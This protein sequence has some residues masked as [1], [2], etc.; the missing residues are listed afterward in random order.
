MK[1]QFDSNQEYQ[2]DAIKAVVDIFAGQT[3]ESDE[4]SVVKESNTN[5]QG[6]FIENTSLGNHLQITNSQITKNVHEIQRRNSLP[7]SSTL[8]GG[9]SS[10]MPGVMIPGARLTGAPGNMQLR[11]GNNFTIEMETGTGK[12]Y[13]YLRTIHELHKTYGF[14][15]FIIVVPSVAIKEGVIKNL[16]ITRD[17][18]ANIYGNP[19]MDYHVWDPRKRGQA[20]AFS[21]NNSLQ[22]LVLTIDSFTR[23]ENIINQKSDWG[24]PIEMVRSTHPI[25]ILDEP[26]NMETDK[27]KDAIARLNPLSTL[28]YSATHKYPY[29]LVYKLDPVKAYDLGLV[30]KIEVDSVM[31]EDSFNQAYL[32]VEKIAPKGKGGIVAHIEVDK[33]DSR[34]LQRKTII[35]NAGDN[36][37]DLTGRE[38][39]REFTIDTIDATNQL[40][41]CSNGKIYHVGQQEDGLRDQ[42]AKYQ[43][44]QTVENHFEKE[45]KLHNQ[46]IKV[47]SLFFID[48]VSNYRQYSEDGV[49]KGKFAL[50][51]D[52]I[53]Q[54][55][56]SKPK[57][58]DLPKHEA[59]TVHNGYFSADKHGTWLDT[60]GDTKGDDD[61]YE[62]IMRDKERLL[63]PEIPLRFIFTHSALREGWDNP[64]VFQICTLRE[65]GS[66]GE[67]RQ[68]I[69]RGLRLPVNIHGERIRDESVN[70]LTVIA[71]ESYESFAKTLQTEI[72]DE[73]GI[74]FGNRVKDKRKRKTLKLKKNYQLDEGFIS[75]WNKIKQKTTFSVNYDTST[76]IEKAVNE[77][78][79]I[80][81][82]KPKI[83]ATRA[84]L[85]ITKAGISSSVR[86][87]K[88]TSF[89]NLIIN[90][91]DVL[92]KI[93]THTRLTRNTIYQ[94][95]VSSNK[96]GD[97]LKNPQALIDAAIITI[98]RV[99]QNLMIDGIKYKKNN[100]NWDMQLFENQELEAYLDNLIEVQNQEKTLYNYISVDSETIERP[101][102]QELDAREDIKY[103][104]KLPHWFSID[105]PLGSY[106]P[107]WAIVFE[108]DQR[109]Y[110]VA[111]TKGTN[112]I[113]SDQLKPSEKNKII[114]GKNHFALFDDLIYKAPVKTLNDVLAI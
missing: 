94:I 29:N 53:Y 81:I 83:S 35:V 12:T 79:E 31:S 22:I 46:G 114:C 39:Y 51:F 88:G 92:G 97:I 2:L 56:Q 47:L 59:D 49:G 102:A 70:I 27:R 109:I 107:D 113:N 62:L 42:I 65:M 101:F 44:E 11:E 43:I 76:L 32:K 19:K 82:T 23:A 63:D 17:H 30:K 110:F 26:Q 93:E 108:G 28:R 21:T 8:L 34:G 54:K 36:L 5:G 68:T 98:N 14:K 41:E 9:E 103:Y 105:T 25:V 13:V 96:I 84:N 89:D 87:N 77:L 72:E 7:L 91:P 95:L 15:K 38:I 45:L 10:A 6:S 18:F 80:I 40:V 78:R 104:F 20:R 99:M 71:N 100:D 66:D 69:G 60:K 86:D 50:W 48:K 75:I 16:Q 33:D 106:N 67:R 64:N 85:D 90:I 37:A 73:T 3:L 74:S 112:D 111:E 55:I 1:L 24:M 58:R 4:L 57:Y 61:T 52:E